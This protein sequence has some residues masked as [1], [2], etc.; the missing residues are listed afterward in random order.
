MLKR[1]FTVLS[2]LILFLFVFGC[3]ETETALGGLGEITITGPD[4]SGSSAGSEGE[5]SGSEGENS[6]SEGEN[7]GSEG[8]NSGGRS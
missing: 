2:V 5:N 3:I 7:S 4:S 1:F 8:E 6:G